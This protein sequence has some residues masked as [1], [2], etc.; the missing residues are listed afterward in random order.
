MSIFPLMA[1]LSCDGGA[2]VDSVGP[3]ASRPS[4]GPRVKWDLGHR[5]LPEIPLPNDVATFPDPSSP[6]GLRINA[7][8]V[9]PTG[10]ESRQREGFNELD[11]WGTYQPITVPFDG[12]LDLAELTRRMR[13]DDHEF[14]DD[15]VYLVNLRT[16]VPVPLD[17]GDGAFQYTA[18]NRDGYYPNDPRGGQSNLI[19]ETVDEDTN[20]NGALDPGE[21]TN[22]D[23]VLNRAAVF[24][25]GANP[26][27]AL[28]PYWEPDT[29]TLIV[30][31]IVPLE[32]RT[33]YAVVLT[34][35]LR[36]RN[37]DPVRSPYPGVAH[38]AQAAA[39]DVLDGH[40]RGPHAT[41][42]GGLVY[43]P[44]HRQRPPRDA[45]GALRRGRVRPPPR[46]HHPRP[47]APPRG[48]RQRLHPR[49]GGAPVHH[50]R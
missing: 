48:R 11:G 26:N 4:R 29:R 7:S 35:R 2:S 3:A 1:A 31:P 21:D 25:V 34:D 19:F 36:G 24:P 16:G 43:H 42:Y 13:G 27:D 47:R 40:L 37:G 50:P 17:M 32:E 6:T 44:D 9:T 33:P 5:P 41:Y 12:D 39:L 38:P 49:A 20:R 18:R 10:F 15:A 22:F 30:R 46:A 14:A 45:Q 8:I 28:T 23:G